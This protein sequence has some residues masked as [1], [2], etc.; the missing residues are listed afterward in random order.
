[1]TVSSVKLAITGANGYIGNALIS[2]ALK[3]DFKIL[4][5]SRKPSNQPN[6][7]WMFFDLDATAP[8]ELPEDIDAIS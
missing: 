6:V 3:R 2:D 5:L 7:S 1:M 4:A 8:I